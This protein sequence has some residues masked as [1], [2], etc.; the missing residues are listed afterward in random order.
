MN[1]FMVLMP[2]TA[3]ILDQDWLMCPDC[4]DAWE[5][6]I[7]KATVICPKCSHSF[8]NPR[9]TNQDDIKKLE[10]SWNELWPLGNILNEVCHGIKI[11]IQSK[12]GSSYEDLYALLKKIKIYEVNEYEADIKK[13]I[14]FRDEEVLLLKRCLYEVALEIEEWEFQT[15][16]GVTLDEIKE[17]PIFL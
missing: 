14:A 5:S 13:V 17:N 3:V 8:H 16:I 15:R 2:K 11:D 12:I 6:S 10:M 9:Y 7:Q 1:R 4:I